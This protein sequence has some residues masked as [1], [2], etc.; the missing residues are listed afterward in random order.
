MAIGYPHDFQVQ[1]AFLFQAFLL[2]MY[3]V[4]QATPHRTDTANEE[5]QHLVFGKK[6]RVMYHVQG[7]TERTAFHYKRNVRFRSALCTSYHVDAV[8]SQG[9]EKLSGNTR[10]ML[11]VLAYD[12]HRGKSAFGFHRTDFAH[13]D[14]FSK[15]FIEHL[16]SQCRIFIA[17]ADRS[18]VFRRSLR[19]EEHTDAVLRQGLENTI[20]HADNAYHTQPRHRDKARIVNRRNTFDSFRRMVGLLLHDSARSIGIERILY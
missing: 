16:A 17:H 20:V 11:H 3:L 13:F 9:T 15:L 5:I 7:L 8:P 6:E 14:F 19:N 4:Y 10:C 1:P 18:G 12:S 2:A